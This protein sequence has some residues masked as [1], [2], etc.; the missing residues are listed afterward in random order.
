MDCF[1]DSRVKGRDI[2]VIQEPQEGKAVLI[3]EPHTAQSEPKP[4]RLL[5]I[6]L[7]KGRSRR[8]QKESNLWSQTDWV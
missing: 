6:P 1:S 5:S 2:C 8:Q 4:L 7:K 3:L